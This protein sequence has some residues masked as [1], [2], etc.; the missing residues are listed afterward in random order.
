MA[1]KLR[2]RINLRFVTV[3]LEASLK[4]FVRKEIEQVLGK[5]PQ[6]SPRK[7][8]SRRAFGP[9]RPEV[10]DIREFIRKA[11]ERRNE[12]PP[13]S[14]GERE[15]RIYHALDVNTKE[16]LVRLFQNDATVL[17]WKESGGQPLTEEQREYGRAELRKAYDRLWQT[18][19]KRPTQENLIS[20]LI[21]ENGETLYQD[22]R[23]LRDRLKRLHFTWRELGNHAKPETEYATTQLPR[24]TSG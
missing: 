15:R 18:M 6:I 13:Y 16:A 14:P 12:I 5:Q 10:I 21:D 19:D 8:H 4:P 7:K 2:W 23:G 22:A 1:Y 24:P 20:E 3:S 17:G 11:L 9:E